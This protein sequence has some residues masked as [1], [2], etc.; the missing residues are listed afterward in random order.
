MTLKLSRSR[1]S[2]A[3]LLPSPILDQGVLE[4]VH[5]QRPVRQAGQRVVERLIAE[6]LLQGLALGDVLEGH[7]TPTRRSTRLFTYMLKVAPLTSLSGA[8]AT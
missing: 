5:E 3:T 8:L 1:N 6:L 4:P 7:H 2:T